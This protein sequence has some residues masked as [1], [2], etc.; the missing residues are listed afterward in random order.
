M[1]TKQNKTKNGKNKTK[2][3]NMRKNCSL[4]TLNA[5]YPLYA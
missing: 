5:G 1:K 2:K 4:R 3:N